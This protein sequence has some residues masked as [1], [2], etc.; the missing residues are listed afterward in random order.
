MSPSFII[1]AKEKRGPFS[2]LRHKVL[3]PNLR[4]IDSH[5]GCKEI[6]VGPQC[7]ALGS[8]LT[9]PSN[10]IGRNLDDLERHPFGP[11]M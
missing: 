8:I 10:P 4:H 7:K 1:E 9:I 3:A 6:W 2:L 5:V 11:S